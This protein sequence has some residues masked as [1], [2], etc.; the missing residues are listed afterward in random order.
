MPK[1]AQILAHEINFGYRVACVRCE[2]FNGVELTGMRH[3]AGA[4]HPCACPCVC[5]ASPGVPGLHAHMTSWHCRGQPLHACASCVHDQLLSSLAQIP[6]HGPRAE[7]VDGCT[8][9]FLHFGLEGGRSVVLDRRAATEDG[10]KILAQHQ[11]AWDRS[12]ELRSDSRGV[13]AALGGGG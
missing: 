1:P 2:T 6:K 7:L 12:A 5:P 8:S 3:L 10:P 9:Q 11:I 4:L 13:P